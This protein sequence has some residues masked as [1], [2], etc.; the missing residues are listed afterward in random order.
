MERLERLKSVR[1]FDIVD[2]I[3][4]RCLA[5][6]CALQF[7]GQGEKSDELKKSW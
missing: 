1:T 4:G 5:C 2:F 3:H 7:G 6:L